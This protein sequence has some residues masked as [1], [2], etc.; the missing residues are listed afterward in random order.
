MCHYLNT[1]LAALLVSRECMKEDIKS[2][3][4]LAQTLV[5]GGAPGDTS[6][7]MHETLVSLRESYDGVG[8]AYE[9]IAQVTKAFNSAFLTYKEEAY[10]D[11]TILDIF[12][13]Y[14]GEEPPAPEKG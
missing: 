8:D 5:D 9:K 12:Q 14:M 3:D 13:S 6:K 11:K 4:G 1:H 7:Q 10:L 2:L